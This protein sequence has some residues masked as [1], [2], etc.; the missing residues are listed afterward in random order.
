MNQAHYL[1]HGCVAAI[2]LLIAALAIAP[3]ATA[4][5]DPSEQAQTVV[6]MLDYV[7]VDYPE[8][9]QAGEV[10]DVAEY[11]EQREF[12]GQVIALLQQL[13]VEPALLARARELLAQIDAKAEGA[14][15]STLAAELRSDVISAFRLVV[16]P[17][18]AP[19]LA[20][21]RQLFAAQ[22]A[23]CHGSEGRGDGPLAKGLEPAPSDF[24]EPGRMGVRSLYGLYNTISLG[25]GGT[26]MR[27]FVELSEAER[28]ALAFVT[29]SLRADAT[30]L[31]RGKS[32]WEQGRGRAE[33][34]DLSALVRLTPQQVAV[35]GGADLVAVQ[36]FLTAHPEALQAAA[37]SP[38]ALTR[39]RLDDTLRH[40]RAG[41]HKAARHAAIGAYLDGFELIE[42]GLDNVDGA[43]RKETE[44][45]MMA[46][47]AD[48]AAARPVTAI[49]ARVAAIETLLDRAGEALGAGN[50]SPLT[51]FISSLLILLRE[52]LEAILVLAAIIAFVVKTGRRDAL[53]YIHAGWI[54]AVALGAVTWLV[55]RYLLAIS[56]ANRELT[57]GITALLAAAMLL[58]V[59][60]W[61]HNK[62]NAQAWQAFVQQ[63]VSSALNRRTLWAMAGISFLAV[64]RELFEIILFYETLWSQVGADGYSAVLGGIAA[65]VVLLALIGGAILKYSVRLPIGPFF[66]VTS[67][68]L[69]AMAV[70][71]VG[72]GVAALQEAGVIE[73]TTVP[74]IAVPLLGI[75]A[76]AE[77]LAM[78][79]LAVALIIAGVVVGRRS[80]ATAGQ[81]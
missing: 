19:D 48:I 69:A 80:M 3:N 9:V 60:Y 33:L 74:F 66:A 62:S 17:R 37:P 58:Y 72:N 7:G 39:E 57:E 73:A 40:Y 76:T 75:H 55:A 31:A 79:A 68:L 30:E 78:Q 67:G 12:A 70:V 8:F 81:P 14:V 50:L 45:A 65:A 71:F 26:S 24:H 53:P 46:L 63:H 34:A 44:A 35:E 32:L 6:H 38:L 47:R 54:G 43:L 11:E 49:E 61:L 27:G 64:Y 23:A 10:I 15:V 77:G 4:Q 22:C 36:A 25:V 20:L 21:G 59:G 51:A 29:G 56:G 28:W 2:L 13:A 5:A 16:T 52:G 41:D 42:A 18:Q 1:G